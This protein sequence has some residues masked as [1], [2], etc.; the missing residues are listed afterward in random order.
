MSPAEQNP[1]PPADAARHAIWEML[2]RRDID[3]FLAQ[4]WAMV[5]GDFWAEGFFGI[6]AARSANPD[7]WRM[8]FT[9]D[10]YRAEWLRQAAATAATAYAGDL[11]AGLFAATVLRDIDLNGESAAVHKKF[12]GVLPRADGGREV[13]CWQ[14]LYLCRRIAGVWKIAGFVGYL[15]NPM[16]G[17]AG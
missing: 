11:R 13:L 5:A 12:D 4:D 6:D 15:P 7:S 14:T 3:A 9:L 1:F 10:S 8:R 2:V 17:R 16:P